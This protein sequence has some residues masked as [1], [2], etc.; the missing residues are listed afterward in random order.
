[1]TL[2]TALRVLADADSRSPH[3]SKSAV[4]V[5]KEWCF[6]TRV[7]S[8]PIV[9]SGSVAADT[10][11]LVGRPQSHRLSRCFLRLTRM[12]CCSLPVPCIAHL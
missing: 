7:K 10:T 1:M 12:H 3:T 11:A 2:F 8:T 5:C 9:D 6:V 4:D